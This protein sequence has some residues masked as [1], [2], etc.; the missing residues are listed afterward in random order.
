LD[1]RIGAGRWIPALYD[2]Q[3]EFDQLASSEI[4]EVRAVVACTLAWRARDG[5]V[6]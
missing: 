4:K 5:A 6:G 2:V 3:R 1:P